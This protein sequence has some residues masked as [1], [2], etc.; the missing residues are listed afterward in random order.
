MWTFAGVCDQDLEIRVLIENLLYPAIVS[1][2]SGQLTRL[3]LLRVFGFVIVA[4]VVGAG[5]EIGGIR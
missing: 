4:E 3:L 1:A 5:H 2:F